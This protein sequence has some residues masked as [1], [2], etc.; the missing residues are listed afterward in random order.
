[1]G[2]QSCVKGIRVGEFEPIKDIIVENILY[3]LP[4]EMSH[5]RIEIG[6]QDFRKK[7]TATKK[8]EPQ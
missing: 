7:S 4:T 3:R 6:K 8:A 2:R 5:G 1:L